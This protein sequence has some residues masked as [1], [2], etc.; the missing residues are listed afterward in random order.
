MNKY[1]PIQF[2]SNIYSLIKLSLLTIFVSLL[3]GSHARANAESTQK[4][5]VLS[6]P[7]QDAYF[8]EDKTQATHERNNLGNNTTLPLVSNSM[9]KK[10]PV[11]PAPSSVPHNLQSP[12][13]V[14]SN[15]R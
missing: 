8:V 5:E 9:K 12:G 13:G 2:K 7:P 11:A 6:I 14:G 15:S 3:L 1:L 10:L 4:D